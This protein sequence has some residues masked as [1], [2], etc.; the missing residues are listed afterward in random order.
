MRGWKRHPGLGGYPVH[1]SRSR[2]EPP[3]VDH[4]LA[5]GSGSGRHMRAGA[6][7]SVTAFIVTCRRQGVCA[8]PPPVLPHSLKIGTRRYKVVVQQYK[9]PPGTMGEVDYARALITVAT[10]SS[11][12]GRRFRH[13][14]VHDTFWHEVTHGILREM[15][16]HLWRSERFVTRFAS[17]LTRAIESARFG[18]VDGG[19]R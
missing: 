17:L 4:L 2:H 10:H 1:L 7:R 6:R 13:N 14:E 12:S 16:H 18:R 19:A 9:T 11:R 5:N 15:G 8:L 3:M